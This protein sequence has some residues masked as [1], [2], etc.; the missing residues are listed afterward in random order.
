MLSCHSLSRRRQ[1]QSRP[2]LAPVV[3]AA[4]VAVVLVAGCSPS[5]SPAAAPASVSFGPD[6]LTTPGMVGASTTGPEPLTTPMPMP[7]GSG[8]TSA[9]VGPPATDASQAANVITISNFAFVPA[10]LTVPVGATVTWTNKD[11]EPHNVISSDG[12]TFH[13]PGLGT[14]ATYTFT[15]PAAGT[16]DYT[17]GIHPFMHGT[18][19]V[20]K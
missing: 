8:A 19:V 20:T 18:V 14:G 11:E 9:P 1:S 10:S 16:F 5:P 3:A 2:A 6:T 7:A 4:V 12:S 13:S 15:F 17:C